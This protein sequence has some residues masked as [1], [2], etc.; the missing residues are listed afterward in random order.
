MSSTSTSTTTSTSTSTTTSTSTSTTVFQTGVQYGFYFDQGR[1]VDCKTCS[2]SCKNWNYIG[3]GPEKWCRVYEW[4]EGTFVSN[5]TLHA[6]FA[7]CYHCANPVCVP[8]A[9]GAMFKEPKYG[10]VLIDPAQARNPSLKAAWD[11]CPY[12][13]IT[14]DSDSPTSNASKCTMCIDRLETGLQPICVM[15]CSYRALDFG[16]LNQLITK[17]GNTRDLEG[18]PTSKTT[19]PSIIF[20]PRVDHNTLVPYDVSRATV[21]MGTRGSLPP[22]YTDASLMTP[23]DPSVVGRSTLNLKAKSTAEF[24]TATQNDEG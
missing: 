7:P 14:F 18:L 11:A 24:M 13:A 20:K 21:L 8:A 23:A 4:E 1:C 22:V 5:V 12:G 2:I 10:A 15:S 3:I 6:L 19:T 16:P 9:N 17:Y